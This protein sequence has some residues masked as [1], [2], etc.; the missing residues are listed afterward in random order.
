MQEVVA[1][2]I[3]QNQFIALV[4]DSAR[5]AVFAEINIL[6]F[7]IVRAQQTSTCSFCRVLTILQL[8]ELKRS[9]AES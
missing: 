4:A 6:P 9:Q 5:R 3:T 1:A 2:V 7:V 8:A